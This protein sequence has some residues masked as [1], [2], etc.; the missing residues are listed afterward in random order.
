MGA[1]TFGGERTKT[2]AWVAL[3]GAALLWVYAPA[4]GGAFLWDDDTHYTANSVLRE[5]GLLRTWLGVGQPNYWP[6]TWTSYWIEHRLFGLDATVSH[7]INLMLHAANVALVWLIGRRLGVPLAWGVALLFAFHP[8]NVESVAWITQRKNLLAM[9]FALGA[10]A[11]FAFNLEKPSR[12]SVVSSVVLFGASLLCKG[13]AVGL[14]LVFL[15]IAWWKRLQF[16]RALVLRVAPHMALAVVFGLVEVVFMGRVRSTEAVFDLSL[17]ERVELIARNL[18]FYLE[19]SLL[20]VNAMF[21]YPR[22]E[23]G[24]QALLDFA[25]LLVWVVVSATVIVF[26]PVGWRGFAVGQGIFLL[27]IAPV[28]GA[29]DIY[30]FKYSF[31]ADHYLYLALP[32]M[33]AIV[34]ASLETASAKAAAPVVL[35]VA[36]VFAAATWNQSKLFRGDKDLWDHTVEKNPEAWIAHVML[37]TIAQNESRLDD[38]Q[39]HFEY[40]LTLSPGA[41]DLAGIHLNLGIV[42]LLRGDAPGASRY[43]ELAVLERP[44]L[45]RAWNNLAISYAQQGDFARHDEALNRALRSGANKARIHSAFALSLLERGDDEAAKRHYEEAVRLD[46]TLR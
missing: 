10:T 20:P 18:S 1:L 38:A 4:L 42:S 16:D 27:M 25:P 9:L 30:F 40:S 26:K 14:P 8:A 6:L 31:V 3:A 5:G 33:I 43:F 39:E 44:T 46:P 34:I 41:P 12:A 37:G 17:V 7:C 13:A 24:N 35:A 22:W 45:T 28:L 36:L 15:A 19:T 11:E 29:I 2:V 32:A 23:L 21:V